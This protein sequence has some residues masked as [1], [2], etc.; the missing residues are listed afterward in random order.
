MLAKSTETAP[1]GCEYSPHLHGLGRIHML[2]IL[3]SFRLHVFTLT[4]QWAK[5]YFHPMQGWGKQASRRQVWTRSVH[6]AGLFSRMPGSA[7]CKTSLGSSPLQLEGL[8][9]PKLSSFCPVTCSSVAGE[10]NWPE[11]LLVWR[12]GERCV[13]RKAS[14]RGLVAASCSC[15]LSPG[16]SKVHDPCVLVHNPHLEVFLQHGLTKAGLIRCG[17]NSKTLHLDLAFLL[18]SWSQV[19]VPV[20]GNGLRL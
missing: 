9:P 16:F 5:F 14:S 13:K 11:E 15:P 8:Q 18:I 2:C 17:P 19:F 20:A 3:Y 4:S 7:A 10:G 1:T 12:R 6:S